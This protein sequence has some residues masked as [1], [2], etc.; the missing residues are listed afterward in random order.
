M[1]PP[2]MPLARASIK[3]LQDRAARLLREMDPEAPGAIVH[4]PSG[5][6]DDGG[7]YGGD[8]DPRPDFVKA[9]D[10]AGMRGSEG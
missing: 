1:K 6:I 5:A 2:V 9:D 3:R 7:G 10:S 4:A 8:L